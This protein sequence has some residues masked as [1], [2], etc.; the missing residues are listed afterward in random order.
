M[1]LAVTAVVISAEPEGNKDLGKHIMQNMTMLSTQVVEF[2][3]ESLKMLFEPPIQEELKLTDK[4]LA[5]LVAIGQTR[6]SFSALLASIRHEKL[7]NYQLRIWLNCSVISKKKSKRKMAR[8]KVK[9]KI[10]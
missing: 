8:S 1:I 6:Q 9:S 10:R 2:R 7:A 4:Q 3:G 5:R